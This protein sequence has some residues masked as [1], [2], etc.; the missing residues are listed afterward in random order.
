MDWLVLPQVSLIIHLG[1]VDI[2]AILFNFQETR[3]LISGVAQE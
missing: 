2:A 3:Q 1:P